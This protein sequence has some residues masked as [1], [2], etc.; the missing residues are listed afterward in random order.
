[1]YFLVHIQSTEHVFK[2]YSKLVFV[3][4]KK[5]KKEYDLSF[6]LGNV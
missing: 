2:E 5:S 3:T 6:L 4:L 1:M